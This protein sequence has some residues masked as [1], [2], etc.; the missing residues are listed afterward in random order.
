MGN[1]SMIHGDIGMERKIPVPYMG[2]GVPKLLSIILAMANTKDG[3]F[4]STSE[5][6][7]QYSVM[8]KIL[9]RQ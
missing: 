8:Q 1:I 6:G 7:L 3:M 4:S 2:E 9:G 5:N